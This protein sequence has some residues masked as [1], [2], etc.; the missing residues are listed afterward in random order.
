MLKYKVFVGP[1]MDGRTLRSIVQSELKMSRRLVR[2]LAQTDGVFLNGQPAHLTL[3]AQQGDE[4][5]VMLP[6]EV[7]DL[8]PE[9][10]PLDI[11][12]EDDEILVVNKPPGVLSHPTARERTGS[13]LA[14]V[15]GYLGVKF[16]PHLIHRLDRNTSGLIMVAKHAHAHHLFD[17]AL[18][19]G[20]V[21]R[22]YAALCWH[23]TD[24]ILERSTQASQLQF[25]VWQS[26]DV[27]IAQ[28]PDRPSK[29]VVGAG[30]QDAL[31]LYRCVDQCAE[32]ALVQVVL[33]TGRTHQ[34]RL[35]LASQGLPIAGDLDYGGNRDGANNGTFDGAAGFTPDGIHRQALHAIQL[36]W[37]HPVTHQVHVASAKP[38]EDMQST[39]LQQGG[40]PKVWD[41][42]VSDRDAL[43]QVDMMD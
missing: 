40:R 24:S 22:V 7:S 32:L 27:P 25:G 37:A 31:T 33:K 19:S 1:D 2:S 43:Q 3:R 9:S 17:M 38:P 6:Q 13:L 5:N 16:A 23:R 26:V 29:R 39:W 36:A 21:H 11:R 12:Y 34:I 14:G 15:R 42:F 20:S 4:I 8:E 30:G 10:M 35:H 18:R 28:D 41:Q